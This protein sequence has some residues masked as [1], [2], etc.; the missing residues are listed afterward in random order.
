MPFPESLGDLEISDS[1]EDFADEFFNFG[2]DCESDSIV[3]L[4][5]FELSEGL[6]ALF[7]IF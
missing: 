1:I 4:G 7:V 3:N 5:C 6:F 2:N